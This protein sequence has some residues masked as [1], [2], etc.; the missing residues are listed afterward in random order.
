M[1]VAM[2][3]DNIAIDRATRAFYD[4]F[5]NRGGVEPNL[6]SLYELFL[7]QA[8]VTKNTGSMPEVHDLAGFVESRRALLTGGTLTDFSEE[9]VFERTDVLGN[10]AQRFSLYRKSW[11]ESGRPFEGRGVTTLQF[12]RT[13]GGWKIASVAWD[14][15]RDGLRIPNRLDAAVPVIETE[16]LRLRGHRASD[17]PECFAMWSDP[18]ITRYIGGKPSSEQQAWARVLTFAG[19]WTLTGFGY[20][21]IEE[22]ATG[23][24]VGDLG[25][26]DF[27][28]SIAPSM[29]DVPELGWALA[30]D[31]H[32]R[33]Y[34]TEA[35][36]A[37]LAWG[38]AHFESPR[39]VC[40]I[41]VENIPSIRV[42][43]KIGY[44]EFARTVFNDCPTIFFERRSG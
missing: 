2:Q 41:D 4:A 26:A 5:T 24:Y 43:E 31:F 6:D 39:T 33:G 11:F 3:P 35:A 21:A 9:E 23:R 1:V 17:L 15:E 36:R 10:V 8:V 34:A 20:W 42:A 37:A 18:A 19:L 16:R 44:H 29:K 28:R 30:T 12:V 38:D 27:H 40:M 13:P 14:D 25:F 22:K 7:P 32:G